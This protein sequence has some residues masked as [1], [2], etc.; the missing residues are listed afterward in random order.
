MCPTCSCPLEYG[1]PEVT[2]NLL[3]RH[4]RIL[5]R[6]AIDKR[7]SA[8]PGSGRGSFQARFH[9]EDRPGARNGELVVVAH[10]AARD[11]L[12]QGSRPF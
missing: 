3:R 10:A 8:L 12:S 11:Q 5:P 9:D 2:M 4:S 1:S 6:G 7:G